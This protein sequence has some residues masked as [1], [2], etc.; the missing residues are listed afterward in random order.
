LGH[1]LSALIDFEMAQR[2]GGRFLR[3]IE[4]IDS[5]RSRP[6]F[7]AA[8]LED[9]HWLGITWEEPV[10]RQSEHFEDYRAA[11]AR[12]E[13]EGLVYPGFESRAGIA[14]I[15]AARGESWPRDPDGAPLY[16]GTSKLLSAGARRARIKAGSAYALRLDIDAARAR[17]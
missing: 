10:R 9:L 12:L 7:E 8:I 6:E 13:A 15:V 2:A 1:A 3:R 14:R 5:T 16:P 17:A 4:D 11:L